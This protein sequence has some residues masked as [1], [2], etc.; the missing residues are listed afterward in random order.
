MGLGDQLSVWRMDTL[1]T[2][3]PRGRAP[4]SLALLQGVSQSSS[5]GESCHSHLM[6]RSHSV[7]LSLGSLA[8]R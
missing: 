4:G 5:R 1:P 8:S 6:K 3:W 7:P 2:D